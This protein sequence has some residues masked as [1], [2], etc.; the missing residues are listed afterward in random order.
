M[1]DQKDEKTLKS[2]LDEFDEL[3]RKFDEADLN[4]EQATE[5]F[6]EAEKLGLKIREKLQDKQ[7]E[8]TIIRDDFARKFGDDLTSA[9]VSASASTNKKEE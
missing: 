4:I 5:N 1:S 3:V 9:D 2:M 8:L 7:N 6:K